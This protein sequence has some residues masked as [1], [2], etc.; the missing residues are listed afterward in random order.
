MSLFRLTAHELRDKIQQKEISCTEL[1]QSVIDRMDAVE[2]QVHAYVNTVKE[3]ALAEAAACDK[4]I[5]AGEKVGP[6]FGIPISLKDNMSSTDMP[7]TSCSKI[8]SNFT[9]PYTATVVEKIRDAG[10]IVLGKTNMDEFAMGSSTITSCYGPTQNPWGK[11]LVPGGSSGGAAAAVSAGEAILSLGS[12]T[13]GSI[14]QPAAFCGVVGFKPTYGMVSRYG[15]HAMTCSLDQVGPITKDVM[16]CALAMNAI[17]GYDRRDAMSANVPV[18]DF[19]AQLNGNI[20]GMKIGVPKEYFPSKLHPGIQAKVEEALKLLEEQ[21][22]IVEEVSLPAS[23]YALSAYYIIS[24]AEISLNISRLDGVS[25]GVREE[26]PNGDVYDMMAETR[27]K[28]LGKE[29]KSRVVLG[30]HFLCKEQLEPYYHKALKVRTL[31]KRDFEEVFKKYDC[32]IGPTTL[33]TSFNFKQFP[34]SLTLRQN[35]LLL[36]GSNLA[37]NCAISIPCGIVDGLP[38]GLQIMGDAF[39]DEKVLRMAY[40]FEQVSGIKNLQPTF[41]EGGNN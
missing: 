26:V 13:G 31:V 12:D 20:K 2:D 1:T 7:T 25:Y 29:V 11:E 22:A 37:G 5:A 9:A 27:A 41:I 33:T 39:G 30:T 32:I 4:K 19:T 3:Q 6:L 38:I 35:D 34:D 40:C 24:P 15:V 10:T 18:P 23:K 21:G 8:L 36:A 16:D 14:R 17:A 28:G